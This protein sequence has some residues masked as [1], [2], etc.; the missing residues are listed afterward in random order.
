MSSFKGEFAVV[1]TDKICGR[2]LSKISVDMN[3]IFMTLCHMTNMT[4]RSHTSEIL[5]FEVIFVDFRLTKN[6]FFNKTASFIGRNI[7]NH[8]CQI[9]CSKRNCETLYHWFF[10]L[11]ITMV[12]KMNNLN[13]CSAHSYLYLRSRFK[14]ENR[15]E[16]QNPLQNYFTVTFTYF[17]KSEN[18]I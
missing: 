11:D 3:S 14:R 10:L 15:L 13:D 5:I 18:Q 1:P 7:N 17:N 9:F 4:K 12:K 2:S 8:A 16:S 6:I